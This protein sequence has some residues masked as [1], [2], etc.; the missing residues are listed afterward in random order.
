M[1]FILIAICIFGL[2]PCSGRLQESDLDPLLI[3]ELLSL[4][5]LHSKLVKS[6]RMVRDFRAV[7]ENV[8]VRLRLFRNRNFDSL[9]YNV[10]DV[11][12]IAALIVGDFE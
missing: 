2:L 5:D 8:H 12:E 1:I 9:T 7:N 6:F 3:Q 4:M 10:P 11:D